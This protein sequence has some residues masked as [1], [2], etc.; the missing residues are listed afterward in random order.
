MASVL[1]SHGFAHRLLH[2][3]IIE[4]TP[5]L[6]I[7]RKD[8]LVVDN[9]KWMQRQ[10]DDM[11][12]SGGDYELIKSTLEHLAFVFPTGARRTPAQRPQA[13]EVVEAMDIR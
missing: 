5:V 4:S 8:G 13:P 9:E 12:L 3:N 2:G 7:N 10:P 11:D 1:I 6:K